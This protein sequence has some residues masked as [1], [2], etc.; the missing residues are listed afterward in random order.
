[1]L[2]ALRHVFYAIC[3]NQDIKHTTL[4]WIETLCHQFYQ[5]LGKI[6]TVTEEIHC[7]YYIF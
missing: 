3:N 7:M 1:M 4:N 5:L 6:A 2:D